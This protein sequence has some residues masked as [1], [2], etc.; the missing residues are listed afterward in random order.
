LTQTDTIVDPFA[1]LAA[2]AENLD[3][4]DV[5]QSEDFSNQVLIPV[6]DYMNPSR[7]LPKENAVK[8]EFNA[9]AGKQ[10]TTITLELSGGL[11]GVDGT[12]YGGGKYPERLWINTWARPGKP[13]TPGVTSSLAEYMTACGVKT[14]GVPTSELLALLP[15]TLN[16]PISTF[17]SRVDKGVKTEEK[18]PNGKF[19]YKNFGLKLKDFE[20]GQRDENGKMIYASSVRLAD[21]TVVQAQ[22]KIASVRAVR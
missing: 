1:A 13:G 11:H 21:G 6:G 3:P 22:H 12:I 9:K 17:V 14:A 18:G 10:I 4:A 5:A 7:Q 16:T 15:E 8:T 19:I 20:T 2:A